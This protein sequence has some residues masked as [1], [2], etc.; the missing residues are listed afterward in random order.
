MNILL[1][2]LDD[3]HITD[4]HGRLVNFE[5]TVIIMTTNAGS[6]KKD[7][8]VGF[9]RTINEQGKEKAEKAL[10]DFLRPE[11]INRVDE[12]V[13]FNHLSEES[14]KRIALLMLGELRDSMAEKPIQ[15]RWDDSLIDY[16]TEKSF[17]HQYGARNLRR[18][19]QKEIED[20][21][22]AEIITGYARPVKQVGL[23]AKNGEILIL[24]V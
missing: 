6:D 19:I 9:N 10:K 12:V 17:S 1:Q 4:A 3:G 21:I 11:F 8:M 2:I 16:L 7:G 13:Y 14:F 23:T 24:A 15:L 22:A 20:R 5:N 18:L